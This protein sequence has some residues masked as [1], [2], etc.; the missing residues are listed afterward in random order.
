M[1]SIFILRCLLQRIVA[2]AATAALRLPFQQTCSLQQVSGGRAD[3]WQT[4]VKLTQFLNSAAAGVYTIMR[5]VICL[6]HRQ[7]H[8]YHI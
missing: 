8:Y 7:K 4:L 1:K 3:L 6:V 5:T 2:V